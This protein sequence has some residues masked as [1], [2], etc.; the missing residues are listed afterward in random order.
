MP[1]N[2]STPSFSVIS[3]ALG[4][5]TLALTSAGQPYD[6]SNDEVLFTVKRNTRTTEVLF[7]KQV[8]YGENV[9]IEPQNTANLPYGNYVYDVQVTSGAVVDTVIPPSTFSVLP[10]VTFGGVQDG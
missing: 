3:N 8:I 6:Y 4:I 7:Q 5:F 1:V 2:T 9:T 10:E